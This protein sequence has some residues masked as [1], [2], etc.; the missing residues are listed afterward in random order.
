MAR[1]FRVGQ[2]GFPALAG[3]VVLGLVTAQPASADQWQQPTP[4]SF[5]SSASAA[6]ASTVY[7]PSAAALRAARAGRLDFANSG[8]TMYCKGQWSVE[9]VYGDSALTI[10]QGVD[11][12]SGESQCVGDGPGAGPDTT[13][14]KVN[15]AGSQF[16]VYFQGCQEGVT[17]S[18][19]D[20]LPEA[21]CPAA[22]ATYAAFGRLPAVGAKKATFMQLQSLGLTRQQLSRVIRSLRAAN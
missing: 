7:A 9:A 6:A 22:K 8:L 19:Q 5:W 1:R 21:T 4:T 11:N 13:G 12:G 20:G 15:V 18:Q 10:Q 3:A 14:T 17:D 2:A 16:A